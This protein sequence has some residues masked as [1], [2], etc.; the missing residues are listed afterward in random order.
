MT[1]TA[2]SLAWAIDFVAT[3]SDGDLFPKVLEMEA[4]QACRD[5]FIKLLEANSLSDFPP[6]ANRR[7]IVPKDEISYRQATQLDPQDAIL[8]S[9]IIYEFGKGIEVRR[10]PSN[11]VF[12]Y[13]FAP[14]IQGGLFGGQTAWNDFWSAANFESRKHKQIIPI[15]LSVSRSFPVTLLRSQVFNKIAHGHTIIFKRGTI[16]PPWIRKC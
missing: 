16:A 1:L 15:P 8:L 14:T 9:A 5:D 13:R 4:V 6:G 12:S 2:K 10:L 11:R 7:F 3:H